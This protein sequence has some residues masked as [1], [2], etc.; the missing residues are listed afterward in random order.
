MQIWN[1]IPSLHDW[2]LHK[3]E[4]KAKE[5]SM[6]TFTPFEAELIWEQYWQE[7][8]KDMEQLLTWMSLIE[9]TEEVKFQ[10]GEWFIWVVDQRSGV[11]DLFHTNMKE[12]KL[13]K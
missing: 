10:K 1:Y 5:L 3:K 13:K 2:I 6:C 12:V 11:M 4:D 7:Y 9:T 8:V